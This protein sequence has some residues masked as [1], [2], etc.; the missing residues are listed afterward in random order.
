MLRTRFFSICIFLFGI[1][2]TDRITAGDNFTDAL[3]LFTG[4]KYFVASI[5]FERV[6]FYETDI[7]KIAQCRYYKSLCYKNSGD[8]TRA[9]E[10]LGGINLYNLPDTL[11]FLIRYETA[12]CNYLN[13]DPNKAIWLIDEIKLNNPDTS[14]ILNIIPLNILCLNSLRKWED[15]HDLLNYLIINSDLK[16]LEKKKLAEEIDEIYYNKSLPKF[17]KPAKAE[18]LSRFIP[19][20]GQMYSGAVGEG[21]INFLMNASILGFAAY[22]FYTQYYFTGYFVGLGLLNKTYNGGIRRAGIIADKR[23]QKTM[24][25]FNLRISSILIRVFNYQ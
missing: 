25:E 9:I 17:K 24:D 22:E 16:E 3:R 20:S 10:E 14:E 7:P 18:N 21:T 15:A 4:G 2:S 23:N 1:L 12:L 19:G 11:L 6:I 5:E 8:I 13:D